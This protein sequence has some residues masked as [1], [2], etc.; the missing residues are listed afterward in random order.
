MTTALVHSPSEI[1]QRVLVALGLGTNPEVDDPTESN[2]PVWFEFEPDQP[3]NSITVQETQGRDDMRDMISGAT[4]GTLGFQIRVRANE[5]SS[6]RAKADAVAATIADR[7]SC[8]F[9]KAACHVALDSSTYVLQ[10]FVRIGDPI[11]IGH[12]VPGS[13]R[14]VWTINCEARIKQLS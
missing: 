2:W 6:G 1:V 7:A 3:D 8:Y 13:K 9:D 11:P 5:R 14:Q 10:T 4:D 12:D